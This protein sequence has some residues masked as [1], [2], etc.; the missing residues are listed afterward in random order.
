[1]LKTKDLSYSY[2]SGLEL[3]FPDIECSKGEQCLI[4]GN[5]GTGK[6]TLLHLIGGLRKPRSGSVRIQNTEI[7][8]LSAHKLDAFR[9]KHISI[10]FQQSHFVRAL[11]VLENLILA[12]QLA[13][14]K[15]DENK[16][17]MVLD[18]LNILEKQHAKPERLSVGEQQRVAIARAVINQPDVI[19][20]D[21]PTSALDDENAEQVIQL[22]KEQASSQNAALLIV[23]HDHRL[24]SVFENQVIL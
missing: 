19:L 21:E 20:A 13:G 3:Q 22:L 2:S 23:T 4:L 6:T 18:Q 9:G 8:T 16:I 14:L 24:K 11:T 5:S 10:V 1:M 7:N 12:Q 17:R 15:P